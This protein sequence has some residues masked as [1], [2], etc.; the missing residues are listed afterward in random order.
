MNL[1]EEEWVA[2]ITNYPEYVCFIPYKDGELLIGLNVI[3]DK[4]PGKLIGI[5]HSDGVDAV[6][7][8]QSA[9]PNIKQ[10]LQ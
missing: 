10:E 3:T 8:F 2:D 5:F 6:N 1:T 7:E 9:N 4:C